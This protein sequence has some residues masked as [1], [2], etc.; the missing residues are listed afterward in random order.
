MRRLVAVVAASALLLGRAAAQDAGLVVGSGNFFSPVVSSL[1]RAI[2][3]YHDGLGLEV[4]GAPADAAGN[5][6]LRNMFGLPGAQIRWSVARPAG[7]R[8]GVEIVEISHAGEQPLSRRLTDPG[9]MTL[10]LT[11]SESLALVV[12]RIEGHGGTVVGTYGKENLAAAHTVVVRDPDDH[13]V[14]L[15]AG[16]KDVPLAPRVR[17]TVQN[18]DR[19]MALYREGLGLRIAAQAPASGEWVTT[20]LGLSSTSVRTGVLEVPGSNLAIEFIQFNG[21]S[22]P[23]AR[24]QDPGA[25]RLQLQVRDVDAAVQAVVRAGGHVV[26]SGGVPVE[27]PAGRGAAIRAVIVQDPDNLFLVMIKAAAPRA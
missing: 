7:S 25:T 27:L 4:T 2:G 11:T 6:P 10:V 21:G 20:A 26:S 19:T 13:F 24:I 16:K 9:A 17:L 15:I 3:F 18:L 12:N 1:E 8:Q 23:N 22:R 5:A 14:Q